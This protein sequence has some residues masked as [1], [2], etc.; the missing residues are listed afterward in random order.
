VC[1]DKDGSFQPIPDYDPAE[2][3][4]GNGFSTNF[5]DCDAKDAERYSDAKKEKLIPDTYKNLPLIRI[6]DMVDSVNQ[7]KAS[8]LEQVLVSG[9]IGWPQDNK[10]DGVKYGI[11]KDDTSRPAEQQK[12]WDY[13]PICKVASQKSADGNIYKAYGGFRLKKFIDTF[14]KTNETNV[15]SVCNPDF[16]A[17]MSQIGKLLATRLGG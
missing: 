11:G 15:F 12:L 4:K 3:Y 17:A 6:R 10:L 5:G 9:V 2:G 13:L 8:P 16:S 7:V 14:N 1:K